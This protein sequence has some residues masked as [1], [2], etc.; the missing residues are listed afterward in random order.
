MYFVERSRNPDS[1]EFI[2][3]IQSEPVRGTTNPKWPLQKYTSRKLC[4]GDEN[5]RIKFKLYSWRDNGYHTPYGEFI[6][7]LADLK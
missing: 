6:T 7:T 3:V 5:N 1:D 2:R 4:N